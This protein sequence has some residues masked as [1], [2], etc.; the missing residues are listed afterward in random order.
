MFKTYVRLLGLELPGHCITQIK[1]KEKREKI[2]SVLAFILH[3]KNGQSVS[4]WPINYKRNT[5]STW[6]RH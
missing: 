5:T 6:P 3:L 1:K 2:F 4:N